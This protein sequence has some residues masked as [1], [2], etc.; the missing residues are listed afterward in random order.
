VAPSITPEAIERGTGRSWEEWLSFFDGIGASTLSHQEI[1]ERATH[2]GAEPWWRQMV[3]VAY[4]QHIGRRMPG[5]D[6]SGTFSISVS[7]TVNG[8]VDGALDLWIG[9]VTGRSEFSDVAITRAP[10]V[11]VTE[12]WR[13]WR[14]GL[15]D[16]SRLIVLF[17]ARS[18]TKAIVNVQQEKVDSDELA[19]HWRAYW[20]QL[21][22]DL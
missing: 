20:K 2:F 14:C 17:S 9:R 8:T 10:Q 1:V 7:K 6:G 16:G 15:A 11:S 21:L 5:Q 12:K 4:E 22:V 19:A 3:T 13:Y 18:P